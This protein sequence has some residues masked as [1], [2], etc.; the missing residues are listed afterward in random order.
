[1]AGN[2]KDIK[3][4]LFN[5]D[6]WLS[7]LSFVSVFLFITL[8]HKALSWPLIHDAMI[9]QYIAWLIDNGQVPYKDIFDFNL[10]GVYLLH[11]SVLKIFGDSEIGFRII[12]SLLLMGIAYFSGRLF[13]KIDKRIALLSASL[14]PLYILWQ[15]P[16]NALQRDTIVALVL[17]I[18]LNYIVEL[19]SKNDSIKTSK[20]RI[21]KVT[22]HSH[23]ILGSIFL[24][25]CGYAVFV[26]P[27][28]VF[29]FLII[30]IIV[31]VKNKAHIFIHLLIFLLP[32]MM[33]LLWL[34]SM[35]AVQDFVSINWQYTRRLFVNI[36]SLRDLPAKAV[37]LF[38]FDE[39][40]L[41]V[42][43][44]VIS[45]VGFHC[46]LKKYR[47]RFDIRLLYVVM[48]VGI[49]FGLVHV[50][51]QKRGSLYHFYPLIL[52]IILATILGIYMLHLNMSRSGFKRYIYIL[53]MFFI[54]LAV[55]FRSVLILLD[56]PRQLKEYT[57]SL[58]MA[59]I[60]ETYTEPGEPVK[61]FDSVSGGITALY[62]T[63]HPIFDR[64]IY[65]VFFFYDQEDY[66]VKQ[67]N[68]ELLAELKD[69][70]LKTV[71]VTYKG[72]LDSDSNPDFYRIYKIQGVKEIMD[73]NYYIVYEDA[74]IRI[75]KSR[76]G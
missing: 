6:K 76:A 25:A 72:S 43:F 14:T 30:S 65:D 69:P 34:D 32:V 35:G 20:A 58:A 31:L 10:P 48:L 9:M 45:L 39:P 53:V 2:I 56:Q 49:M 4:K 55:I 60:I 19:I 63:K 61:L 13:W 26:K 37:K 16:K 38:L 66:Y 12:D 3:V 18:G 74:L 46:Y 24:L 42:C 59:E 51:V 47:K 70:E 64:F 68:N 22:I 33:Q 41:F 23:S 50:L 67:L 17:I 52:M 62:Q 11:L 29:I 36:C 1:M 27:T 15:G 73:S 40:I 54:S 75:Y 7:I 28:V 5:N 8:L 71:I 21:G 57:D 44:I